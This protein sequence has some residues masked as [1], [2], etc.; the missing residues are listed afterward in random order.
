MRGMKGVIG[1]IIN[2][3][4]LHFFKLLICTEISYVTNIIPNTFARYFFFILAKTYWFLSS[5]SSNYIFFHKI[6][7]LGISRRL[8]SKT[9]G[10]FGKK[11]STIVWYICICHLETQTDN[12][13]WLLSFCASMHYYNFLF[14]RITLVL[15]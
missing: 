2:F 9:V 12:L 1:Q 14:L 10:K 4:C 13:N 8:F 7:P 15:K 11:Y 3:Y 5:I 6:Y